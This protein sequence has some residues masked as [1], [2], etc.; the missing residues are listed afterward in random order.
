M[1]NI[2]HNYTDEVVCPY[3]GKKSRESYEYFS[4]NTDEDVEIDCDEC[5]NTFVATRMVSV[6]YSTIKKE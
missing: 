6:S 4:S 3:C 5:G 1:K 2:E